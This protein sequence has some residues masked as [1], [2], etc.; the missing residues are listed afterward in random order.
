MY[1]YVIEA[2]RNRSPA[3]EQAKLKEDLQKLGIAG[4]MA[5]TN[6]LRSAAELVQLGLQKG[7][8]TIIAVGDDRH[9]S[10]VATHLIGTPAALG[11]LPI[12]ASAGLVELLGAA[13]WK[14]ALLALKARKFRSVTLGE[15]IRGPVFLTHAS[16]QSRLPT[17][18]QVVFDG[19]AATVQTKEIVVATI[20]PV[21]G[22]AF[23]GRLH[24]LFR[25]EV[26]DKGLFAKMF[27]S[28]PKEDWTSSFLVEAVRVQ[29]RDA[30]PVII[31]GERIA[32][33]PVIF[34][35]LSE[36]LRLIVAKGD[37]APPAI[38]ARSGQN[39]R[40]DEKRPI[41]PLD[42]VEGPVPAPIAKPAARYWHQVEV[43]VQ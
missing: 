12:Q 43:S 39:S 20:H 27:G 15:V 4:E 2:Q 11:V 35:A 6:P 21:T 16:L 8:T 19:Y 7:A 10:E 13:S 33:T 29:A 3:R 23:P 17:L 26:R 22:E 1:F 14:D 18:F 28:A 37:D 30:F 41:S 32:E 34:R 9:V 38:S 36:K 24:V 40:Q 42:E 31:G 5:T 25:G